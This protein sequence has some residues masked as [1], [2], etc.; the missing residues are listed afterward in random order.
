MRMRLG[1]TLWA[2]SW[3]P[4][5]LILGLA[6]VWLT[7]AWGFEIALGVVGI[8]IAGAEFGRAV[9]GQGWRRAPAVAWHALLHGDAVQT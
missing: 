4:Y 1:V 6:G 9:K 3:V 5:G 2:L 8:A 7:L